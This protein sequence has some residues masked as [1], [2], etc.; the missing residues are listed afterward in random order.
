MNASYKLLVLLMAVAI[1]PAATGAT[2]LSITGPVTAN[3]TNGGGIYLG[4]VGPGESFYVSA[5][6]TTANSSGSIINIGWDRLE[7]V[8]LPAGWSSQ[9]SLL[10]E[11][12]MKMKITASPNAPYGSY[13]ITLRAVN[14]GNYS[15]L[16]NLTFTAEVN[17]SSNVFLLNVAPTQL[18]AGVGQPVNLMITIN[19]TGISDDPFVINVH[20]IPA[21][22]LQYSA[23]SLHSTQNTFL[24]PVYVNVPGVY[25]FNLTVNS[26]T[27]AEVSKSYPI[28]MT[29][30]ASLSNDYSAISQGVAIT[31]VIYEPA[32]AVMSLVNYI[33]SLLSR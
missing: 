23:I 10:Y 29:V 31:P 3:L 15:R 6:A 1:L 5:S 27:S 9:P 11:N 22:N 13:N 24:Y 2:Y 14:V 19:N 30:S 26:S 20:G 33:S 21:W 32:Y 16:G 17:V 8:S 12:P 25:V 4:K 18:S 28:S 7:A